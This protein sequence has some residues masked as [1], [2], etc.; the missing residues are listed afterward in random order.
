MV[1]F[2]CLLAIIMSCSYYKVKKTPIAS[3]PE[4]QIENL[5]PEERYVIIH[6]GG[7][8][9]HLNQIIVDEDSKELKGVLTSISSDHNT[10]KPE[11]KKTYRYK[12][13]KLNPLNEVHFYTEKDLNLQMGQEVSIPFSLLDSVSVNNPNTGR[14]ILNV[15]LTTVGV[16]VVAIAVIAATK[17]SCPFVYIKD[18]KEFVFQGELYPGVIT[19]NIQQDDY[20]PLP[21]FNTTG[22]DF[23]I[24]VTNELH[25][26]QHTDQL[27]LLVYEHS[28]NLKVLLDQE[29]RPQTFKKIEVPKKAFSDDLSAALPLLLKQDQK[30][31]MFDSETK[32][33]EG[34]RSLIAEFSKP[35]GANQAKLF[36]RVKNSFWLD[37]AFGK[38]NEQFGS[39]YNTFQKEQ[40]KTPAE[41]SKQWAIDQNIPLS[42]YLQTKQGWKLVERLNTV[43]PLAYRD[44]VIHID[45][46]TTEKENVVLKFETGFMFWDIDRLGIDYSENEILKEI[47]IDP[48]FAVD[49]KGKQVTA[50]LTK[51]D[52]KYLVQ[53]EVGNEVV[54]TFKYHPDR[55]PEEKTVFLKNR[56]Y[57]TYI[58][59]YTGIPNFVK[60][61]SFKKPGSFSLFSKESYDEFIADDM[62]DYALTY[63]N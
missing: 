15:G 34:A 4:N 58:R 56:G 36:L 12:K 27:Q 47:K 61:Q 16:M 54:V 31:F 43:G 30:S 1:I 50:L 22:D 19:P 52:G 42:I 28:K 55:Q 37:Y 40:L 25:E 10:F 57:Y 44:I 32:T 51:A 9:M 39:Y 11:N 20:I 53:P 13:N 62:L 26:I 2:S 29:G 23:V 14:S 48:S 60:L 17:S 49:E 21:G 45:L 5:R 18:G 41:E 8:T 46:R 59:N 38:F 35:T 33:R 24:K 7:N 63:G 3:P 6:S